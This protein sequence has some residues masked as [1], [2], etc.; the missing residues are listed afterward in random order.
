[1]VLDGSPGE[2]FAEVNREV[3]R[4]TFLEPPLPATV[5]H[6]L[7]VGSTPTDASLVDALRARPTPG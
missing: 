7:G 5:G 3:L 1:V 6:R 4:S 2:V